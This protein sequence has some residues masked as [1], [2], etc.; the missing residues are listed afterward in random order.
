MWHIVRKM[1]FRVCSLAWFMRRCVGGSC[2]DAVAVSH[3][4]AFACETA[5]NMV[6]RVFVTAYLGGIKGQEVMPNKRS[7]KRDQMVGVYV[8]PELKARASSRAKELGMT[9][10][11][12][13]RY[14]LAEDE[15]S[16]NNPKR[17]DK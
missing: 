6:D 12:Y 14:L 7:Q 13:V 3:F 17:K 2:W 11:D 8:T 15:P 10:S 5:K 16:E 9:L 4:L 1:C